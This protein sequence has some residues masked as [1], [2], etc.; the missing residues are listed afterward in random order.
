MDLF[1][2]FY[3][4]CI[5]YHH[6]WMRIIYHIELGQP[7]LPSYGSFCCH[8]LAFAVE[9][10]SFTENISIACLHCLWMTHFHPVRFFFFWKIVTWFKPAISWS[11]QWAPSIC[12]PRVLIISRSICI[13]IF[14]MWCPTTLSM[15]IMNLSS[16][17]LS[18]Y[19]RTSWCW[20]MICDL[21][22][23]FY[24]TVLPYLIRWLQVQL[25][26]WWRVWPRCNGG[27]AWVSW[28]KISW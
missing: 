27:Q 21:C 14:E 6:Y 24:L 5:I 19:Q 17:W 3:W 11:Q 16:S 9:S 25:W 26:L 1:Y 4:W 7:S 10:F 8:T 23:C 20:F 12:A 18:F 15:T 2:C 13:V 22:R 28:W